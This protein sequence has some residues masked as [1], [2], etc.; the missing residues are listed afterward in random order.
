MV[1][2]RTGAQAGARRRTVDT[3]AK[4]AAAGRPAADSPGRAARRV[5]VGASE[6]EL[7]SPTT[8]AI[9]SEEEAPPTPK[10]APAPSN[11]AGPPAAARLRL[12][13]AERRTA[14]DRPRRD[15]TRR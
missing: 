2:H 10:A 4:G 13:R 1:A 12:T 9:P 11:Q 5:P 6:A 14:R 15:R 3:P 7:P 8:G